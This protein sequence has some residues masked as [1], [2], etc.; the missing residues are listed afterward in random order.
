M[1]D[2]KDRLVEGKKA[3]LSRSD[4]ALEELGEGKGDTTK[5]NK[6]APRPKKKPV[7][8]KEKVGTG[9]SSFDLEGAI[10]KIQAQAN[11]SADPAFKARLKA[12]I[13]ALRD[14]AE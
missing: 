14:N 10:A 6:P 13:K 3:L 7:K 9:T 11:A 5:P 4:A 2:L 12:R 8:V 1:A